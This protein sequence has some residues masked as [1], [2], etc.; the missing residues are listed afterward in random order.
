VQQLGY[1]SEELLKM[2]VADLD[3]NFPKSAW[4]ALWAKVREEK[5]I[6]LETRHWRKDGSEMPVE[7]HANYLSFQ[8]Q[9]YC[10][11]LARDIT[12]RR[13]M[14]RK[15]N[16]AIKAAENLARIKSEFLANMSHEIRTP[17]NGVL[18]MAQIGFRESLGHD[19]SHDIFARIL[20]SGKL[21]LGIINDI[22]DF[23][24][25][26]AGKL[27]LESAPVDPCHTINTALETQR[28]RCREKGI[29]LKLDLADNLPL[30]FNCDP[31]RLSQI[32]LNLLSN[33][34][35]FTTEG[36]VRVSVFLINNEIVFR[37]SDSGI[38]MSETQLDRLFQP[39]EQ[40]DSST[41][42][43]YGGTG[44]GLSISR[45][46][47]EIM[48][49][50]IQVTSLEGVGSTFELH[51]PCTPAE[52]G[53]ELPATVIKVGAAGNHLQGVRI[54]AAE[55]NEVNQLVL[56]DLLEQEGAHVTLVANGQL[57]VAALSEANADFDIVL[58]DAQMPIMDGMAATRRIR[59]THPRLPIIGQTAHALAEEHARCRDAG[60]NAVITK[61]LDVDS[62]VSAILAHLGKS[63]Q[64][65][66]R[67]APQATIQR[68][69]PASALDWAMLEKK[70]PLKHDFVNKLCNAFLAS[71]TDG[72][73]RIRE[74][75]I[76]DLEA[77]ALLAHSLKGSAGSLL[78]HEVAASAK[79]LED[80]CHENAPEIVQH[81]ERLAVALE[82]ALHEI[83][84]H[85]KQSQN[86]MQ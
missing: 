13:E 21:L 61:P 59:E 67:H 26:E 36:E 10:L 49:G 42:R 8:N 38:G 75:A 33:A 83:T 28:E 15:Q 63:G 68:P 23:S 24:K 41:T 58:M 29:E 81:A 3:H 56:R 71:Y 80:A 77:L 45:R 48:G 30:A 57:A 6:T 43:K 5:A 76:K 74:A 62:L 65:S 82:V 53:L 47:A 18:G 54:L 19:R 27:V 60:M 64:A 22:L 70:Y 35:K 17:L 78:A 20:G 69:A 86:G 40:A 39:F 52:L 79:T 31:V 73:T 4:P 44:L 37:I 2:D 50:N 16:E 1:S 84:N 72:P 14:L 7:I 25:I 34:V 55:D 85:I 11:V 66:R 9:D 46:L 12:K 32:L 51:L